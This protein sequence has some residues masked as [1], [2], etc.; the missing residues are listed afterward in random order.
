MADL[1]PLEEQGKTR[2]GLLMK[3]QLIPQK[4]FAFVSRKKLH[5]Q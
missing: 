2:E 1:K 5:F 3:Q 4:R